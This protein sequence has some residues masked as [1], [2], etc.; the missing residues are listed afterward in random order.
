[1]GAT[2]RF[3]P[4]EVQRILALTGKQLDH[5]DRLSLVSPKKDQGSRFY[6]FRDLIGLRTIKRLAKMGYKTH[7]FVCIAGAIQAAGPPPVGPPSPLKPA[8]WTS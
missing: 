5:W 1:M 3:R 8:N 4:E 2:D 6:D 7:A